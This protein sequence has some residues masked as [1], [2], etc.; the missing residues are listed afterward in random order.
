MCLDCIHL[1]PQCVTVPQEPSA[2]AELR[3]VDNGVVSGLG[4]LQPARAVRSGRIVTH[5]PPPQAGTQAGGVMQP[6][7]VAQHA[8][9]TGSAGLTVQPAA[10]PAATAPHPAAVSAA[11]ARVAPQQ[12]QQAPVAQ[13]EAQQQQQPT[14]AATAQALQPAATVQQPVATVQAPQPAAT[15]PPVAQPQA[16]QI[17][18]AAATLAAPQMAAA[19]AQQAALS[20]PVLPAA[21]VPRGPSTGPGLPNGPA[22]LQQQHGL[23]LPLTKLYPLP[24]VLQ[25]PPQAGTAQGAPNG[26]APAGVASAAAPAAMPAAAV[27]NGGAPIAAAV[28][29][30]VSAPA[31]PEKRKKRKYRRR[32]FS[33]GRRGS[34]FDSDLNDGELFGEEDL[35]PVNIK[36]F[37]FLLIARSITLSCP[38][39]LMSSFCSGTH[40]QNGLELELE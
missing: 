33:G 37:L 18:P 11:P 9:L 10:A 17:Q 34:A 19:A 16:V 8:V 30:A 39:V 13:P 1:I 23:P 21:S 4:A 31:Q 35:L 32:L 26:L 20:Q 7:A 15:A 3:Q 5:L 36:L 24:P 29:A 27:A 6:A 12:G 28:A 22:Q 25:R 2:R 14:A 40:V 38:C